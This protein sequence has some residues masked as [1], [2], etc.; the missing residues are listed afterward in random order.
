MQSDILM[1]DRRFDPVYIRLDGG[2]YFEIK[3]SMLSSFKS[4][5]LNR[6]D[7]KEFFDANFI[8]FLNLE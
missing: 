1:K 6:L 5:F 3:G 7:L 4:N 8:F 2:L